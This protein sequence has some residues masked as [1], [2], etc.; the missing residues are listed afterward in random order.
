ML[1]LDADIKK[2]QELYKA[3]FGV[4]IS[5][6]EALAKGTQLLRLMELVYKPMSK[7]EYELVQKRR[8]ETIPLLTHK[9]QNHESEPRVTYNQRGTQQN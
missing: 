7:E 8:I 5:K 1:L 9:L 2:F 4:D 3:R 6:D